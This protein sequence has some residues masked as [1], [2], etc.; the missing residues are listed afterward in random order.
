MNRAILASIAL[1]CGA[2]AVA[3]Q[4]PS[5]EN[6]TRRMVEQRA[7][8]AVIWG[9]PAVNTDLMLQEMLSETRVIRRWRSFLTATRSNSLAAERLVVTL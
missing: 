8:E 9:M 3:A 7:V 5:S 2:A 6:L 1:A 4:Q